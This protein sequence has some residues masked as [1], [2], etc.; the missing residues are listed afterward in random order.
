MFREN[1]RPLILALA[2]CGAASCSNGVPLGPSA[3]ATAPA[4]TSA[5]SGGTSGTATTTTTTTTT[6]TSGSGGEREDDDKKTPSTP[7]TPTTPTTPVTT[8]PVSTTPVTTTPVTTTPAAAV[9]A[10][11]YTQDV[12]PVFASDCVPCHGGRS[13]AA[14][15]S[16]S[17]YAGVMAAVKAGSASSALVVVTQPGGTMY[18]FLSGDRAGKAAL[19]RAWVLAGAPQSR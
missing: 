15:Y 17:T 8:T 3:A 13:P 6:S 4:T 16:M 10:V 14:R 2:V 5:T 12:Q 1:M 7:T 18:S 19:I 11:A 9:T